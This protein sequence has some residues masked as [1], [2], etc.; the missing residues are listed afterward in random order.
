MAAMGFFLTLG[1]QWFAYYIR[2][3]GLNT[4]HYVLIAMTMLAVLVVNLPGL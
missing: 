4:I 1:G 3:E 2:R